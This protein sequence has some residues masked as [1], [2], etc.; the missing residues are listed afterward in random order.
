MLRQRE[1]DRMLRR[2]ARRAARRRPRLRMR[3][4]AA[5]ARDR[6]ARRRRRARLP[7][8]L[9]RRH[10]RGPPRTPRSAP[11]ACAFRPAD[12]GS[13]S[14]IGCRARAQDLAR[15]V[16]DFVLRRADGLYAYQL[17]V[18]VDDALTGVTAVVRGADLLA[19]T[20]RQ[21]LLQRLLGFATPSYLH[22]P[23]AARRRGREAVQAD[24]GRAAA[25]R[26]AAGAASPRGAS[27]TSRWPGGQRRARLGRRVLGARDAAWTPARLPPVLMLPA[28]APFAAGARDRV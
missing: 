1:R 22:A 9:P 7:G 25:G 20:P 28:P 10:S 23:V 2:G 12:A 4:H 17:A 8:H 27:S 26:P 18:V 6:S 11:G 24:A 14:P 19:S 15:D 21:I 3:V 13:A 16:G 5:R